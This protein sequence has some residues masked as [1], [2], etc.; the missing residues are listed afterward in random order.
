[1]SKTLDER[2]EQIQ[3][4]FKQRIDK[5]WLKSMETEDD[6]LRECVKLC[7]IRKMYE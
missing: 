3:E 6:I 4:V 1:M 5:D 7:N 2:W